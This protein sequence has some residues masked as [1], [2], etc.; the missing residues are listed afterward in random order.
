MRNHKHRAAAVLLLCLLIFAQVSVS[1]AGLIDTTHACTLTVRYLDGN[2]P[3]SGAPFELYRVADI[4]AYGELTLTEEFSA[5]PVRLDDLDSD[6]WK[7]LAETLTGYVLRDQLKPLDSGRTG[8]DGTL[9][10]PNRQKALLPGLYLVYGK[11]F[12]TGK[13]NY[14]T[15]PFLVQLPVTDMASNTWQYDLTVMPKHT[16]EDVPE[17]PSQ[18]VTRKVL[19]VWDDSG[20]ASGRPESITVQ[21]LKNGKVYDTVTLN[22]ANSWR[23]TWDK[24]PKYDTDGSLIEWRVVET[25]VGGYTVSVTQDGITTVITNTNKTNPPAPDKPSQPNLPQTGVLWW[26]AALLS[27]LG[28]LLLLAARRTGGRGRHA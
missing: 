10:F 27:V 28:V 13:Y 4:S 19:K 8:T 18:T 22:S 6:G 14:T 5:Y 15:E 2:T 20:H 23:Y 17:T 11:P 26:P 16:R 21:L 9:T 24:L 12:S 1:A 7:T 25:A 3:I